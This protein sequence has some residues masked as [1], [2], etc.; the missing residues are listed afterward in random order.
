MAQ[1][2]KN[3]VKPALLTL[4]FRQGKT[5]VVYPLVIWYI[6]IENGHRNS[7]FTQLDSMVIFQ[8][9]MLVYQRLLEYYWNI[10]MG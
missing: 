2:K 8:Y 4:V 5:S 3:P 10:L 6:A 1:K 9:A 7:G